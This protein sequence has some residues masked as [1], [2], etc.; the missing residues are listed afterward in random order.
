L[1]KS[2]SGLGRSCQYLAG[3]ASSRLVNLRDR[4]FDPPALAF[5]ETMRENGFDPEAHI[6]VLPGYR[7]I[8]LSVPKCASTTIKSALSALQRGTAPP[9]D[10]IHVRRYSGLHSPTQVGL[11]AFHRL[12]TGPATLRFAF[13]RNPYAR[14]VSAWADKFQ[15]K[16]LAAGDSFVDLYLAHRAAID[17]ALP[18]GAAETLSFPQFVEFAVA[19]CDRRVNAH[20]QLQDDLLTMPGIDLDF[21]GKVESF[22]A[23]FERVMDHIGAEPRTRQALGA[24][25]NASLH[26]PWPDYYDDALVARVH[27]AYERDFGRFGYTRAITSFAVA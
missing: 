12:A 22:R 11:S 6:D 1:F 13:V 17:P 14:L 9:P 21:T 10:K 27:R 3:R 2:P 5:F 8:Y 25:F 20:W 26:W 19:T 23:D 4:W 24:T 18:Q 7:L 16:P 15:N